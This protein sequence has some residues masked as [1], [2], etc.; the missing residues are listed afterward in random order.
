MAYSTKLGQTNSIL[1]RYSK[2][3]RSKV[4]RQEVHIL[5]TPIVESRETFKYSNVWIRSAIKQDVRKRNSANIN[6]VWNAKCLHAL[7]DSVSF[8]SY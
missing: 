1:M 3:D 2:H 5:F 6:F 8:F 7:S 4:C